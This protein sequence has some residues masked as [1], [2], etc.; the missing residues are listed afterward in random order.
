MEI[1]GLAFRATG[2]QTT[3]DFSVAL[4]N[5]LHKTLLAAYATS[6]DTWRRLCGI[7]SVTDFRDHPVYRKGS[8]ARLDKVLEHGEFK[9]KTLPDAEKE[10][11]KAETWGNI[12]AITRQTIVNDDMGFLTDIAMMLGRAAG[13]SIELEVYDTLAL[14]SN[15]GPTMNDSKALFHADHKNIS[16]ASALTIANLDTDIIKMAE[17]KDPSANEVLDL[18]PFVLLV[19]IGQKGQAIQLANAE[20]EDFNRGKPNRIRGVFSDIVG[21]ARLSGTRR[22]LFANPATDASL[23][24]AFLDGQQEPVV[25]SQEQFGIDGAAWKVRHDFGVAGVD[26]RTAIVNDG[27]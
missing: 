24:V 20:F 10:K 27:V 16:T 18:Q 26:F 25:E 1:A 6:P 3:S 8:I 23:A 15:R 13:L 12:V 5:A 7:R 21:T 14:N 9:H 19:P 17:Q 4:E 2:M 11:I 22:F